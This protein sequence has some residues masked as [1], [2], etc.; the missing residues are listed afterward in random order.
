MNATVEKIEK[1]TAKIT[2][3]VEAEKFTDALKKVYQKNVKQFNIPGFRK[4]KA[5]LHLIKKMYGDQIF[6]PE[7]EEMVINTTLPGILVENNVRAVDR[8]EVSI[9]QSEEGK[10][11]TYTAT[12]TTMPEVE[13]GDYKGVT[14]E[15]VEKV[16]TEEDIEAELKTMQE[17]NARVSSKAE[18]TIENGNIAVIDFEGFIAGAPF[19][20]GKGENYELTIGSHSFIDT[21]EDQLIGLNKGDAKDVVVTFPENY[22]N[23]E[24][25]G[26][27]ATFKVTVNDIKVKELPALDDEFA[28]EVSE[29]ETLED[30]KADI[31][32]KMDEYNEHMAKHEFQ[33]KAVDAA[34]A[35]TTIEIPQVMVD[36]EINNMMRDLENRLKAQGL[37][38]DTYFKFT[39]S[40]EANVRDYM[41]ETA[42]K[43]VKT[44]LVMAQIAK[45]EDVQVSDEEVEAKAR[46]MAAQWGTPDVE[47]T[48]KMILGMQKEYITYDLVNQKV[49]NIIVENAK[50]AE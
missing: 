30:L 47:E 24:L 48:V 1:N 29:F 34:V 44:E 33:E 26:K 22:G 4:G 49:I 11:F 36:N 40:N 38:L 50:V 19:Q 42:E 17:K 9:E 32:K 27:E 15:K 5:P 45:V 13:L 16:A 43:R 37:D 3:T 41:K 2:V 14:V 39:N 35:N 12:V 6:Y 31:K 21:F 28:K 18:G 7:A 20:G 46:E 10:E 25:N 8:P 23:E